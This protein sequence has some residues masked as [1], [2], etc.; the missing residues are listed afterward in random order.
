MDHATSPKAHWSIW[1]TFLIKKILCIPPICY[2]NNYITDFKEKAEI[3]NSFFA[4]QCSI[5]K[6][7]SQR[8][9]D[10]LKRTNNCLSTI[11]FTKDDI[12]KII[13]NPDPNKAH[14]HDMISIH[15][16]K[17]CGVS[18]L[19]PLELIFKICI[20]SGKSPIAWKKANVVLVYK[21]QQTAKRKLSSNFVAAYF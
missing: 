10:S 4:K 2:N 14:G 7:T 3:F 5:V 20:E 15:I 18:I 13:K 8:P 11:P 19:N 16:I 12:A 1:K 9:T 6:N 17:I 21:K